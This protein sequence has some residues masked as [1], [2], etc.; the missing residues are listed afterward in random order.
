[1]Y[2]GDGLSEQPRPGFNL[3]LA[4]AALICGGTILVGVSNVVLLTQ[5]WLE[6]KGSRL[7]KDSRLA[8][9]L[10]LLLPWMCF[11]GPFVAAIVMGARDPSLV[12]VQWTFFIA[13]FLPLA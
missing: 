6:F 8:T 9:T 4:Q 3:C 2:S 7:A 11:L 12:S 1:L 13:Q 10:L 5:L